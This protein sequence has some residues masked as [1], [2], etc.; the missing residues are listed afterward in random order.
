MPIVLVGLV[1]YL[2][3]FRPQKRERERQKKL[4]EGVAKN[5]RVMTIGGMIGTVVAVKGDE[6]TL[7]VDE[8]TNTR[9]TFVRSAIKSIMSSDGGEQKTP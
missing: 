9:I 3:V 6:V 1:F 7:K 8:S 2:L 5:D 4:L